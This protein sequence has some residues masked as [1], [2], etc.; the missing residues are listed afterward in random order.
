M[1]S[2]VRLNGLNVLHVHGPCFNAPYLGGGGSNFII[3]GSND[4][5]N[6]CQ[7][8]HLKAQKDIKNYKRG[9]PCSGVLYISSVVGRSKV[10]AHGPCFRVDMATQAGGAGEGQLIR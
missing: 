6:G 5:K 1:C 9:A 2:Y 4:C 8:C 3:G 7:N 10:Q